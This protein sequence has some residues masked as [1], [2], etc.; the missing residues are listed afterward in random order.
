MKR[1]TKYDEIRKCYTIRTDLEER[2]LIIQELGVYE[3]IHEK[4]IE[5]AVNVTDIRDMYFTKGAKLDPYWENL[6]K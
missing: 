5:K 1:M 3:D 2:R 6:G 4:D